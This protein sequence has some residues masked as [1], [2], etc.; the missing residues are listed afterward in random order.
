MNTENQPQK[1]GK[2]KGCIGTGGKPKGSEKTGGR[3]KNVPNSGNEV[4]Q[5]AI[6]T[7]R[8]NSGYL[9]LVGREN[10]IALFRSTLQK[11]ISEISV[12]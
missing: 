7:F 4:I 6:L 1:R 11:K 2:Q 10:A 8:V 5:D 9:N 3:G 12:K